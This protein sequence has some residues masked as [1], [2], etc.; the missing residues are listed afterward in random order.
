MYAE[1]HEDGSWTVFSTEGDTLAVFA[2]EDEA[3]DYISEHSRSS[4]FLEQMIEDDVYD[5]DDG[6]FDFRRWNGGSL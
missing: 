3:L 2:N 4:R 5:D 1:Q 6:E